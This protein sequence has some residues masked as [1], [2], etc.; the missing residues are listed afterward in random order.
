[1]KHLESAFSGANEW[2]KY[3]LMIVITLIGA[4]IIGSLPLIVVAMVQ[5]MKTGNTS[6]LASGQFD[7]NALGVNS[8]L[9]LGLMLIPFVV[10]LIL[11]IVLFKPLHKRPFAEVINGT[12]SIRKNRILVGFAF[13]A[14]IMAIY[15]IVDYSFN[16]DNYDLRLNWQALVPLVLVSLLFIPLQS[17]YEEVLFRG[18]LAQGF[19]RLF[20]NRLV[21]VLIPSALFALMHGANPEINEYGFWVMMPQYFLVG[22]V[23]AIVSVLDDGIEL[24]MGAH[25]ANNTFLSI[26]VTAEGTVFQTDALMKM[27]EIDPTKELITGVLIGLVFIGVLAYKYNWS[28]KNILKPIQKKY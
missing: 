21:V 14:F 6:A 9:G 20:K 10:G 17:F 11:F 23:Y 1:M 7:F 25:A 26:F 28:F 16:T 13:W 4:N 3:L 15:L 19:G 2:W 24:A 22:A 27:H 8:T 5:S 18:Y 12:D